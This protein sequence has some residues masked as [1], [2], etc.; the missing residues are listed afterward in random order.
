[1]V[2]NF[3]FSV[4]IDIWQ[5]NDLSMVTILRALKPSKAVKGLIFLLCFRKNCI[6][7]NKSAHSPA[8]TSNLEQCQALLISD[9]ESFPGGQHSLRVPDVPEINSEML[10]NI[11]HMQ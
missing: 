11:S 5:E 1:M 2:H 9:G 10:K 3:L 8:C 7:G 6:S 4:W